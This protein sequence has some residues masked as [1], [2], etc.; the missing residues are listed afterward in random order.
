MEPKNKPV[1]N[2][3]TRF[4]IAMTLLILVVTAL[5]SVC[6]YFIGM[7]HFPVYAPIIP[8]FYILNGVILY[9][10]IVNAEKNGKELSLKNIMLL[11]IIRILGGITLLVAGLLL[12]KTHTVSFV[13]VFVVYY[14][15]YLF[16]E[17][18]TLSDLN[19]KNKE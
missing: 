9:S 5:I 6:F 17:T 8:V 3:W 1:K 10:A 4:I 7:E 13:I 12:D 2:R 14:V 15:I 16:L 19:K 11:R 18:K